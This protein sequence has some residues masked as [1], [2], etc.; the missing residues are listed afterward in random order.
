M[1]PR[2]LF[3]PGLL[4]ASLTALALPALAVKVVNRDSNSHELLVKCSSTAH[5]SVGASSTMDIG[6]GPCTVTVKKSG[7]SAS[8]SGKDELVISKGGISKR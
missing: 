2:T 3:A 5:T 6:K 1:T 4:A 7:A 8:G